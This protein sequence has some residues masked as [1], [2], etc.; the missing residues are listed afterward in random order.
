MFFSK[1]FRQERI[2][3]GT[4]EWD[5]DDPAAMHMADFR[6]SEAELTTSEAM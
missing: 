4:R 6:V 3:N 5:V 1:S 2:V